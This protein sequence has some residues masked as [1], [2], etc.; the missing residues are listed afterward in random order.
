MSRPA[1]LVGLISSAPKKTSLNFGITNRNVWQKITWVE[2]HL[3]R[4]I[5]GYRGIYVGK[6]G[7]FSGKKANSLPE[8]LPDLI[9]ALQEIHFVFQKPLKLVF[10]F[11]KKSALVRIRPGAR[12]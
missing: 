5:V 11:P 1:F 7:R 10:R 9:V 12:K 3:I 4:F 6:P 8:Y 2:T